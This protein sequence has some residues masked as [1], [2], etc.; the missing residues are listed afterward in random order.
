MTRIAFWGG[1]VGMMMVTAAC[2]MVAPPSPAR[3]TPATAASENPTAAAPEIVPGDEEFAMRDLG[4]PLENP[5]EIVYGPDDWLWITERTGK[6]VVRVNPADGTL[7][8]A[9]ALPHAYQ[10]ANQDGV[11]GLALHPELLQGTG[12]DYVYLAYVYAGEG[13]RG[14]Q[15]NRRVEIVRYS[16]D[17]AAG[18]LDEPQVLLTNLPGS[19]DH[20]SGKLLI[21]PDQKLYYTLG[22]Q[23]KNQ[24]ARACL[25]ILAQVLPSAEEVAAED[26]THYQGKV[27]RMNLDGSIPADNPTL[28][29]VQSHVFTYGHRNVQGIA[30]SEAGLLYAT[31][32]GPKSDDEV[33]LLQAGHNYGW[34]HVAGYQDDQAYV[35]ADWSAAPDCARLQFSDFALPE[36]VPQ[37][38]ESAWHHPDFTPPLLTFGTVPTGYDFRNVACAPNEWMCWPTIAPTGLTYYAARGGGIPTWGDAL[39]TTALKTGTVYYLPLSA[40]GR[41]IEG[42]PRAYFATTN[43]YRAVAVAPDGRTFYVITDSENWTQGPDGLPTN[44]LENPGTVLEF[45]YAGD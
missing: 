20:N 38:D 41:T 27:L 36:S 32:H 30:M 5:L 42:A 44:V 40:D 28:D 18:T 14:Q 21:G 45:V 31:E 2:T 13:G 10:R 15:V 34:P 9:L 11:L 1:V 19:G 6:R 4:V 25:P 23:G 7:A 29:G 26:W 16:Y 24:F 33:N 35:Y 3:S 43:R 39:L 37:A 8:V 22:D 17:A 12:N